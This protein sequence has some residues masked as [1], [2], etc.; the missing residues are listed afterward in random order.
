MITFNGTGLGPW[1]SM[2]QASGDNIQWEGP[3]A[4]AFDGTGSSPNV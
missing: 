4:M 1:H 2:G 3:R